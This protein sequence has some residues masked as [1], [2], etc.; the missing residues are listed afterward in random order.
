M[1]LVGYFQ[2][3]AP[4]KVDKKVKSHRLSIFQLWAD[5]HAFKCVSLFQVNHGVEDQAS[6]VVIRGQRIVQAL[7]PVAGAKLVA[8]PGY[9]TN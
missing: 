6:I 1:V 7:G 8:L 5:N 4:G 3:I 9:P 2:V